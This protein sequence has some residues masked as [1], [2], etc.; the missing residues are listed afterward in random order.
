MQRIDPSLLLIGED[1]DDGHSHEVSDVEI[2]YSET[3][4]VKIEAG[5]DREIVGE[6]KAN[7]TSQFKREE[8]SKELGALSEEFYTGNQWL[9]SNGNDIEP[10]GKNRAKLT[11]NLVQPFINLLLGYHRQTR[12]DIKVV[13]VES[14]DALIADVLTAII[15]IEQTNNDFEYEENQVV[16]DQIISGRGNFMCWIDYD[17]NV[18]GDIRVQRAPWRQVSY[19]EHDKYSGADADSV[20]TSAYKTK[21]EIEADWG[22][23]VE[24]LMTS[25]SV[26]EEQFERELKNDHA[27]PSG[28][29][30]FYNKTD[31]T[32]RIVEMWKKEFARI[33]SIIN[34]EDGFVSTSD[35]K[36]SDMSQL[37]QLGFVQ[38]DRKKTYIRNQV[39]AGGDILLRD[40]VEEIDMF[41]MVPV[42]YD[43]RGDKFWGKAS[44]GLDLQQ[45]Y[46][47][48]YSKV[49]DYVNKF[50]SNTHFYD[51]DTF[52]QPDV[53]KTEQSI[54][55]DLEQPGAMVKV[56]NINNT[57]VPMVNG[58]LP[59]AVFG[60]L[61]QVRELMQAVFN[62]NPAFSGELSAESGVKV[63]QNKQ[64]AL[65]GNEKIFDNLS[66][67]K[68]QL[69]KV[70][71][72]NIGV[73]YT[74][75]RVTRILSSNAVIGQEFN[76]GTEPE[77]M[78]KAFSELELDEI[79]RRFDEADLTKYDVAITQ[80]PYSPTTMISNY[81]IMVESMQSGQFPVPPEALIEIN[82]FID[83]KTKQKVLRLIGQAQAAE[84]QAEE[85]ES[86]TEV[87]KTREA[88]EGKIT[89]ALINQGQR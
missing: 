32:F 17:D 69:G 56:Q 70:M 7:F 64:Q 68:K 58:V 34:R 42:Y 54:E 21:A 3:T 52:E 84:A 5:D 13:P 45:F 25:L 81:M 6:N 86:M 22:S 57:P 24:G 38:I 44:L 75:D 33:Y 76:F 88:K 37:E 89:T 16:E 48:V 77:V 49:A 30:V 66:L 39:F 36:F 62:I 4:E 87:V 8:P 12:T 27:N 26:L 29:D 51:N 43:K 79:A 55:E 65:M 20:S 59:A 74:S 73:V 60:L 18:F 1:I 72:K 82:P 10:S 35:S 80:S 15:K 53:S 9:D 85:N 46:N 67:S 19:G 40:E 83:L 47:K 11:V 2:L 78:E 71:V 41:G 31:K 61:Q 63:I 50:V 14:S 23:E 28:H